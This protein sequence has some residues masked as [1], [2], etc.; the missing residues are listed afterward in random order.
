MK[1]I[2]FR[3]TNIYL[4]ERQICTYDT[5]KCMKCSIKEQGTLVCEYWWQIIDQSSVGHD[6]PPFHKRANICH[7]RCG[8][9]IWLTYRLTKSVRDLV[10]A[11]L[12]K[13][14]GLH[15]WGELRRR[16]HHIPP[17]CSWYP[18]RLAQGG[19][20]TITKFGSYLAI[21]ILG[22]RRTRWFVT[23]DR[24]WGSSQQQA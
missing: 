4:G 20:Q 17:L 15:Q 23:C 10:N 3:W 12:S 6:Q 13:T 8:K 22:R 18:W 9:L 21:G 24:V 19:I 11:L 7:R 1:Q 14:L 5:H 16:N 2:Y